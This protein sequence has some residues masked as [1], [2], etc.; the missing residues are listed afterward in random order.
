MGSQK[1]FT[2]KTRNSLCIRISKSTRVC[3]SGRNISGPTA[4]AERKQPQTYRKAGEQHNTYQARTF[5]SLRSQLPVVR[6]IRVT[7]HIHKQRHNRGVVL[8][9]RQTLRTK[10]KKERT[11]PKVVSLA[12]AT[13]ANVVIACSCTYRRTCAGSP[14]GSK[15]FKRRSTIGSRYGRS[16]FLS[17][18]SQK[19]MR[20]AA[21]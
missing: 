19:L 6:P 18:P 21:A 13:I 5:H 11:F 1:P 4:I 2:E 10:T 9:V 3:A 14:A 16:T 7:Q 8:R 20:A 17:T 12:S 15:S